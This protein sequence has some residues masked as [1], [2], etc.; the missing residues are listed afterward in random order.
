MKTPFEVLT[1]KHDFIQKNREKP[2][3]YIEDKIIEAMQE[4]AKEYATQIVLDTLPGDEEKEKEMKRFR[5]IQTAS[6]DWYV[7]GFM[8]GCKFMSIQAT[9]RITTRE[10]VEKPFKKLIASI[11]MALAALEDTAKGEIGEKLTYT[12]AFIDSELQRINELLKE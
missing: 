6:S 10:E 7:E 3:E 11:D 8:Y 5:D 2:S 9:Q 4:Y 12:R 1:N